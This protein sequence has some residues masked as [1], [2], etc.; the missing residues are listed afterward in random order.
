MESTEHTSVYDEAGHTCSAVKAEKDCDASTTHCDVPE[1][2]FQCAAESPCVE[3]QLR[4]AERAPEQVTENRHDVVGQPHDVAV[5][6]RG[7]SK[8]VHDAGQRPDVAERTTSGLTEHP[9]CATEKARN[10]QESQ[11]V[12]LRATERGSQSVMERGRQDVAEH[13]PLG[14]GRGPH[15][16]MEFS[17]GDKAIG[18]RRVTEPVGSVVKQ[19]HTPKARCTHSVTELHHSVGNL[20]SQIRMLRQS[21]CS[22]LEN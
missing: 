22:S 13:S 9:R 20:S 21:I 19:A 17:H 10:A 12:H 11:S 16:G 8:H 7:M 1:C 14:R 18:N 4:A 6:V 3:Q 5:F 2:G 15:S